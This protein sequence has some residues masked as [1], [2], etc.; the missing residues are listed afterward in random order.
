MYKN[1]QHGTMSGYVTHRCRCSKCKFAQYVYNFQYVT[2]MKLEQVQELRKTMSID[3]LA[4]HI[5]IRRYSVAKLLKDDVIAHGTATGYTYHGCRC[6]RCKH[7]NNERH[8][9]QIKKDRELEHGTANTYQNYGC[10]CEL[11]TQAA[12]EYNRQRYKYQKR[13]D[14]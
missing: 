4:T 2:G 1:I 7:A 12:S 6:N 14:K 3:E 5:G 13:K 11:C 10:R 9:K 8:L